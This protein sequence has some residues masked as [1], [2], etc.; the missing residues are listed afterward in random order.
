MQESGID[1]EHY[2]KFMKD[3]ESFATRSIMRAIYRDRGPKDEK[4]VEDS[5]QK[6]EAIME[7]EENRIL[8]KL[9]NAITDPLDMS[10]DEFLELSARYQREFQNRTR[11]PPQKLAPG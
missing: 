1:D 4:E 11:A 9:S 8:D 7:S 2:G 6:A 10:D 3:I 5:D